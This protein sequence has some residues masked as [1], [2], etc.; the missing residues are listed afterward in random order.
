M[1][2]DSKTF[3]IHS[4]FWKNVFIKIAGLKNKI[5]KA[6]FEATGI[7]DVTDTAIK[8][9]LVLHNLIKVFFFHYY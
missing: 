3:Q 9:L 1:Y 4:F 2:V 6:N 7:N 8:I 5:K